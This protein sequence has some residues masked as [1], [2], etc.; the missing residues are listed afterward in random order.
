LNQFHRKY[1]AMLRTLIKQFS[2]TVLIV[3]IF[4]TS[5]SEGF[6]VLLSKLFTNEGSGIVDK[7]YLARHNKNVVDNF[8]GMTERATAAVNPAEKEYMID[9]GPVGGSATANYVYATIYNPSGSGRTI[10]IKHLALRSNTASST[11]SNYVNLTVRRISAASAGTQIA[12]TN[13]PKKNS[14]TVDSIA[15]VRYAGV[16]AT[17]SGTTDSRMLGQPLSGAVGSYFSLRDYFTRSN[18]EKIVLQPGEGIA[19]YQEAAGTA[20]ASVRVLAEWDESTNAPA[21]SGE[22]IFAFPRVAVAA[23]ANYVYSSFFNPSSSGKTAIVKRIWYGTET[24]TAA[25]IYT[26][27]ITIKRTTAASAGT[28][29]ATTNIPKKNTSS[30][31]TVMDIRHTNVTVTSVGGTEARLASVTPCGAAGQATGWQQ[32]NFDTNDEKLILQ[33]GEGIALTSETAG[34]ANQAVR[35]IVEWQEVSSGSTP[36]SSGEY[37]WASNVIQAAVATTTHYSFFNP[38]GSGKTAIIKRL[39]IA[40]NATTTG[41][42][43]GYSFRRLTA[44]S[45]GTLITSTDLSKKNT[46][47]AT[48]VMEMRWCG[49]GCASAITTTYAG[50]TES[51]IMSVNSPGAVGQTIGNRDV[52]FGDSEDIVLQPGEGIGLYNEILTSS[53]GDA[54]KISIEW[55]ETAVT[56]SSQGEYML[57]IGPVNGSTAASYNYATLFNPTGSG[58]S[59]VIKRL[60]L[61]VDTIAAATTTPFQLRRISAASAGTQITQANIPKKHSSTATSIAE[62]RFAGVTATMLGTADSKIIAAQG[63]SAVASAAAGNP[64]YRDI[65]FSPNEQI[66]LQPGEGIVLYQDQAGNANYRVRLQAEWSEV[67]SASTP[68]SLGEYVLTTGPIPQSTTANYVYSTFFNPV[69]SAKNYLIKRIGVLVN[70]AGTA[71]SPTYTPVAVRRITA[72]SGGTLVATTS[73]AVK[74]S[75]TATSTAQVRTTGVTATFAGVTDS[76]LLGITSP[77]VV[78]QSMG[79]FESLVTQGDELFIQPGEGIALYQEQA[80]GDALVR[81]RFLLEWAEQSSS[82]PPQTISFSISTSTIYFGTV[83]SI[84]ARYASSTSP[85]GNGSEVEAHTFNIATN[86]ANGYTI[87]AKGQTLTSG[88]YT[89]AAIGGTASTSQPGTEQFG[90]RLVA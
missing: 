64:G 22:F 51:R 47:S 28:Q 13:I 62:V 50:A 82:T 3:S 85:L 86:A 27:K 89:V 18:D 68:T 23:T 20:A 1:I 60:S 66:V 31:D 65:V 14:G 24:C 5:S 48:S 70:R 38:A 74:H 81:Y 77:G 25:A 33:Q 84:A 73:I 79:D 59:M 49:S 58:K 87:L 55:Q 32:L 52:V 36:S 78:N 4:F 10:S 56:P 83:S 8:F 44:A 29:I 41:A 6:V 11:A 35:M 71:V 76:R 72:A 63:P 21:A 57:T 43:G 9:I 53:T 61:R 30:S 90:I 80:T 7:M 12:T 26:N 17:L 34:N 75:G 16:T 19:V 67:A 37:I 54:V 45:G 42:Y 46:G 88:A 40:V 2:V 69:G 15:E 39:S